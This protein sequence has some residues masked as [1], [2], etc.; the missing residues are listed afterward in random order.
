MNDLTP[1]QIKDA[2]LGAAHRVGKRFA[3]DPTPTDG[4]I[5]SGLR[6]KRRRAQTELQQ[7][8]KTAETRR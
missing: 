7:N 4:T 5:Q 6:E 3:R 8:K 2:L 1:E